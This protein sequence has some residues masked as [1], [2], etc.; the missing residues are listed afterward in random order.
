MMAIQVTKHA[1]AGEADAQGAGLLQANG[2][3]GS[4]PNESVLFSPIARRP[5]TRD[6][7][8]RTAAADLPAGLATPQTPR[9]VSRLAGISPGAGPWPGARSPSVPI[10]TMLQVHHHA[11][12]HQCTSHAQD[13]QMWLL[14]LP[15]PWTCRAQVKCASASIAACGNDPSWLTAP[16]FICEHTQHGTSLTV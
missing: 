8:G 14:L 11:S 1:G 4:A 12:Q 2:L 5:Y 3:A 9:S 7:N 13:V 6:P 15:G 16:A 10:M